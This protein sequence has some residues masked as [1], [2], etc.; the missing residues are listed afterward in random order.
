MYSFVTAALSSRCPPVLSHLGHAVTWTTNTLCLEGGS[1]GES[2][3]CSRFHVGCPIADKQNQ[4]DQSNSPYSVMFQ[5]S[6]R[7]I[8]QFDFLFFRDGTSNLKLANHVDV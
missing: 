4:T 2:A 1:L 7:L 6:L 5:Y 3:L 8:G